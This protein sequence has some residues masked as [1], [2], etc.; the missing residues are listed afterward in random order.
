MNR[1]HGRVKT[2]KPTSM[3]NCG[4]LGAERHAVAP[5]RVDL[6]LAGRGRAGEAGRAGR[7]RRRGDPA[8]R[9]EHLAVVVE[10]LLLL[11][12]RRVDRPGPVADD[13]AGGDEPGGHAGRRRRTAP[14]LVT[15][16]TR[17][18]VANP[19]LSNHS[20]SV[21]ICATI[22]TSTTTATRIAMV[23]TSGP[24][25]DRP[26]SAGTPGGRGRRRARS[27]ARPPPGR[28]GPPDPAPSPEPPRPNQSLELTVDA[29]SRPGAARCAVLRV[30]LTERPCGSRPSC[31]DTAAWGP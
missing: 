11:G 16:S 22:A 20:T 29:R 4:V 23:G 8:Q 17:H 5:Q 2:K 12:D 31:A 3:P 7:A 27:G 13:Q 18:T 28:P 30:Q 21:Q 6:P 24:R 25:R 14:T 9:V 19:T 10:V 15:T 1:S 26:D